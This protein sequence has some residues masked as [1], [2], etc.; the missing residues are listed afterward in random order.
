[1]T[2][3]LRSRTAIVAR[4]RRLTNRFNW[5]L[6]HTRLHKPAVSGSITANPEIQET[7]NLELVGAKGFE[8]STSWSRTKYL[9]PI[10]ALSGVAYGIGSV[11]SPLLIVRNLYLG[12]RPVRL[13]SST[14]REMLS[15]HSVNNH[16]SYL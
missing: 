5:E 9:N 12:L 2:Q 1:M 13:G 8:P 16:L 10:N 14:T 15:V 7:R 11:I 3:P 4:S 6:E